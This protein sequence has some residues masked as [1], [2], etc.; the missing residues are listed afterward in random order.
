[1]NIVGF[2]HLPIPILNHW[3]YWILLVT[4]VLESSPIFGIFIPGQFF[5]ATGGFFAKIGVLRLWETVF[6]VAAG[7]IIGDLL[8]YELGK[9]YGISF[10]TKYGKYFFIK[11]KHLD[12]TK[13]LM[14]NHAGKTLVLGR[15]NPLTRALAPFAAGISEVSF[16]KFMTYN[17][18]GGISWAFIFVAIGYIFGKSYQSAP[19][20]IGKFIFVI[21]TTTIL[22]IYFYNFI[23]EGKDIK[24]D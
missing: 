1:M 18:I 17:I 2:E 4:T 7:A 24:K 9:R 20:I 14:N 6:A 16:A 5:V 3:G 12:K 19:H 13:T 8:G 15:L 11:Q 10:I 23:E 22:I 21:I